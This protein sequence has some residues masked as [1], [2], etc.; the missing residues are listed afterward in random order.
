MKGIKMPNNFYTFL[1]IPKKKS[2]AKKFTL[3]SKLLKSV[4]FCIIIIIL[5]SMYTY[6]DY[7]NIKR[8]KL[9]LDRL[10]TQTK[11]QMLQ[12]EGLV[13]KVNNFSMKMEEL[14][15]LDKNIRVMANIED[16]RYKGQ[17]LGR[18]GSINEETK[19]KSSFDTENRKIIAKIH[20]NVDQLTRDAT[21]QKNS[22]HDLLKF[23]KEQKSVIAA[24]PSLWPVQGWVTSEFGYRAS[25]FGGSKEFHKGI[26]IAAR[27]GVPVVAPADGIVTEV[28]YDREMGNIIKVDHRHGMTTWYGHLWKS[29]LT[30]GSIVKRGDLMGYVGNSGR[31]TGSHLHFTVLLN[32]VPVNPRK[33]LN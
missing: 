30:Q 7:L 2:S 15:Q 27:V 5:A 17:I 14:N 8:D 4:A 12:I 6:Y 11:E 10:R 32:G 29:L 1:I 28:S 23:L 20:Q 18:G 16:S 26:D 24:T 25:P 13:E 3:S 22:F 31:S 33:Y 21:E 9:E 19:I